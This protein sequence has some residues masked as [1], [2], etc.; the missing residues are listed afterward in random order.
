M[1]LLVENTNTINKHEPVFSIGIIAKK[2][3]IAVQTVRL[4]EQEGLI[5]AHKT[6]SGRRMYSMH[7]LERLYCIRT[8]I[9]EH[10]MNL[11]GIK[12]MMSLIPCWEMKGFDDECRKCPAYYEATG[13]CW[14]ISNVSDKCKLQDCRSCK[15]YQI[16][17]T[18]SKLKEVIYGHKREETFDHNGEE[19]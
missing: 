15:V 12:R 17:M 2:L 14:S 11:Q 19:K 4:Y 9:T 1:S 16:N 10:G 13:P 8:M 3:G 18:C 6:E 7:D 5:I